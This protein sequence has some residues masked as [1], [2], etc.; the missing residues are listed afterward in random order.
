[1]VSQLNTQVIHV[2]NEGVGLEE[3]KMVT[4][5]NID[6]VTWYFEVNNLYT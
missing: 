1:V 5:V 4:T 2:L 6:K 3:L